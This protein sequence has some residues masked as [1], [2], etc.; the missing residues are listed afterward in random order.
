MA[1]GALLAVRRHDHHLRQSSQ[2]SGQELDPLG[3]DAVVVG[4]QDASHSALMYFPTMGA[5][6]LS[7]SAGINERSVI[8]EYLSA[9]PQPQLRGASSGTRARISRIT[10]CDMATLASTTCITASPETAS[11]VSCQ[12][13]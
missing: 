12:Q 1:G 9:S 4:D 3:E 13:S 11:S 10:R 5:R 6:A 8:R 7:V 2:R